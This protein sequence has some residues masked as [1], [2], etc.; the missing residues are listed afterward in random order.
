MWALI[1]EPKQAPQ[2]LE[3]VTENQLAKKASAKTGKVKNKQKLILLSG[4]S[5][6]I[7]E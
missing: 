3:Q 6:I 5:T 4:Q 7:S 1:H 2:D